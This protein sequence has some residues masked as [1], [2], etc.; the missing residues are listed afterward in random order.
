[1]IDQRICKKDSITLARDQVDTLRE[2][3]G[4]LKTL[5]SQTK[6]VQQSADVAAERAEENSVK[7]AE[8]KKRVE[9]KVKPVT[10]SCPPPLIKT[11]T[12]LTPEDSKKYREGMKGKPK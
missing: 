5:N 11:E 4:L 7:M 8:I 1:M 6:V 9:A 2:V 10:L 12:Y 3:T